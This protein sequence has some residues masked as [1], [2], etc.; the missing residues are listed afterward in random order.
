MRRLTLILLI[1]CLPA[2]AFAEGPTLPFDYAGGTSDTASLQ[3]GAKLFMN[4]CSGCHSLKYVRYSR[5]SKD[6]HIPENVMQKNLMFTRA[7]FPE[8]IPVSMP[9]TEAAKWFGQAP[10]DLSLV[11]RHR[12]GDWIYNFLLS[13]YLDDASSTGVNN[14]VFPKTAMPDIVA[15]LQGYQ[16]LAA[17]ESDKASHEQPASPFVQVSKGRMTTEQFHQAATDIT[18]FLVYV[19][20]PAKLIRYNMGLKVILFL[21]VFTLLAWLLKHEFWRDVH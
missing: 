13:F 19:G 12:G 18:S 3:R 8:R 20:E 11:A 2:L 6:L 4:Y 9:K 10:P 16:K 14:L 5:I 17:H 7:K 21:I 1:C 15:P